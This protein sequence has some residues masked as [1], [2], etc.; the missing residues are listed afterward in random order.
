MIITA[1]DG[2]FD[3]LDRTE[4]IEHV[5][6]CVR[7]WPVSGEATQSLVNDMASTLGSEAFIAAGNADKESPF[8]ANANAHGFYFR[9][10]KMDDIT[11]IVSIV[12]EE[13]IFGT[14]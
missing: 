14:I 1:S 2:V 9:G 10:G 7:T 12:A 11:C 13:R 8:A 3:N 6:S 5:S 4:I